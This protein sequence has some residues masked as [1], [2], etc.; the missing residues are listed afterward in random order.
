[1]RPGAGLRFLRLTACYPACPPV[2]TIG[3]RCAKVHQI[4]GGGKEV[5]APRAASRSGTD[6]ASDRVLA[7]VV[8]PLSRF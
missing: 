1:M 3:L 8:T 4:Q 5:G 2:L 7:F 6:L